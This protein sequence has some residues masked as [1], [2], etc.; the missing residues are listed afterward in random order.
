MLWKLYV[1]VLVLWVSSSQPRIRLIVSSVFLSTQRSSLL[2]LDPSLSL[3]LFN[4]NF[5][6]LHFKLNNQQINVLFPDQVGVRGKDVVVLGVEKRTVLQLQDPRTIRKTAMLDDHI[7]LAFAGELEWQA[8]SIG[9]FLQ[10][11]E[12]KIMIEVLLKKNR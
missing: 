7:C 12:S 9:T 8:V 11:N 1:K 3:T 4:L 10:E 2:S 6:S 5:K